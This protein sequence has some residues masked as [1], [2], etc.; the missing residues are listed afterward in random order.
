MAGHYTTAIRTA[1]A[2]IA[3]CEHEKSGAAAAGNGAKSKAFGVRNSNEPAE[4]NG[5][6]PISRQS[7]SA[8]SRL[9]PKETKPRVNSIVSPCLTQFAPGIFHARFHPTPGRLHLK[10]SAFPLFHP[11]G[12]TGVDQIYTHVTHRVYVR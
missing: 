6:K 7:L 9:S 2:N 12:I 11:S 1:L 4:T 3:A 5:G 10:Y 8:R